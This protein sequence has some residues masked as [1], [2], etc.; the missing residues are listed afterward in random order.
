MFFLQGFRTAKSLASKIVHFFDLS[1]EQL[2][3]QQH[4]YFD[5]RALKAVQGPGILKHERRLD[6][7]TFISLNGKAP[8]D[9]PFVPIT[10]AHALPTHSEAL[11]AEV[12]HRTS[13]G[14][15]WARDIRRGGCAH[16]TQR[17]ITKP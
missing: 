2:S 16:C 13:T 3:P 1:D 14:L 4:Y 9:L 7:F 5:L 17:L 15:G 8:S 6:D 11:S 10:A 12:R